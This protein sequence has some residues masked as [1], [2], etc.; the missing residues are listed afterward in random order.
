MFVFPAAPALQNPIYFP[1]LTLPSVLPKTVCIG[2][3]NQVLAVNL[4]RHGYENI[5]RERWTPAKEMS[6]M[7]S[8][9]VLGALTFLFNN[10]QPPVFLLCQDVSD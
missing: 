4:K 7:H 6:T 5:S 9:T 2:A 1:H 10:K 8:R 3:L